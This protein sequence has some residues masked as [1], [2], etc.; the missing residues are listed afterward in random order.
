MK[1]VHSDSATLLCISA[2]KLG[3]HHGFLVECKPEIRH[4]K[5][6]LNAHETW[7]TYNT[8]SLHAKHPANKDSST[9]HFYWTKSC[10]L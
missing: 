5:H 1:Q 8:S 4:Q 9:T 3:E 7:T 10:F 2:V 6:P